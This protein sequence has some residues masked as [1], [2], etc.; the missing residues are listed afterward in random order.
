METEKSLEAQ[1]ETTSAVD[2][3]HFEEA[4]TVLAARPVVPSNKLSHVKVYAER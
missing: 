1:L 2:E 3:P 4:W